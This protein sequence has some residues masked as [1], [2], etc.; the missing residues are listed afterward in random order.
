MANVEDGRNASA[1]TGDSSQIWGGRQSSGKVTRKRVMAG[2]A[3]LGAAALAVG[4]YV[5]LKDDSS[6]ER[7]LITGQSDPN[8]LG[9][10]ADTSDARVMEA[11]LT[12]QAMT[13][14]MCN[15]YCDGLGYYYYAVQW[16][17]ECW[18]APE[19]TTADELSVHGLG[20]CD[21]ACGGDDTQICGGFWAFTVYEVGTESTTPTPS[22]VTDC[23]STATI[24]FTDDI[25]YFEGGGC[26]TLTDMYNA[27]GEGTGPLYV[28]DESNDV[29]GGTP[30]GYWLLDRNLRVV[31]GSTLMVK[32]TAAGG[33]ADVLRLISTDDEFIEVRGYG[34]NLH[35]ESTTVTSWDTDNG[36]EREWDGSG[37]SFINCV[38]QF[39]D[40]AI[41]DC[42]G[43]S[44]QEWGECRMDIISSTMGN[45]GYFDAESYGLTWKVRGACE[46]DPDTG[47]PENHELFEDHN[48]YG[49]IYD[50]EIYGMYY[51]HYSYGHQGG[52]WDNNIMRDNIQY[53]FD[54]HDD[55][56]DLTISNNVVYGNGNHGIIASKRC[57]NVKIFNNEVYDGGE[58]AVGIFLHR[59]SDGA[60]VY[61][62]VVY[63]MQ[64]AG[65]AMM[66][67]YDANI[68]DNSFTNCRYGIRLSLG[69]S[70]N[71]I[72]DNLFSGI[73]QYG[74]YTYMG[75]DD[76]DVPNSDGRPA[77]NTFDGNTI[78]T[79][80][81][82]V[83]VHIKEGD[84]NVFTNNVFTG[85]D[86]YEFDDSSDTTW[87]G[88]T[89]G[90]CLDGSTDFAEGGITSC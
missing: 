33:D 26:G 61:N 21:F 20:E 35:F 44:N 48:V 25:A 29:V 65:M 47:V 16:G 88:N 11:Q 7:T 56:D 45:M 79:D 14:D 58:D 41:W 81:D 67:S 5:G 64:D 43:R 2:G 17:I 75:S 77:D 80:G 90:G 54:P 59:S 62:N 12:D 87:T 13:P 66:E 83:G 72:S 42:S 73:T 86:T 8:A 60:E 1:D 37:R 19:T 3:L 63:N 30:T 24:R 38:T 10:F 74:L 76:P 55:S 70:R 68:Y 39:D 89:G 82:N 46:I 9:C 69:S 40:S 53:G 49:D 34:G 71:T 18:C 23:D 22:A 52:V 50:S 51:G 32:G 31:D 6:T 4:L 36:V 84:G 85:V 78:E 57:N 28:L 15:S 27:Q